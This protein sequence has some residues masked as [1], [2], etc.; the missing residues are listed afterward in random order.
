M[1][2]PE[3]ELAPKYFIE[4]DTDARSSERKNCCVDLLEPQRWTA[5]TATT[6]DLGIDSVTR[7]VSGPLV[8]LHLFEKNISLWS[9]S[10]I[11]ESHIAGASHMVGRRPV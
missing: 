3:N 8:S 11:V 6:S 4:G 2:T 1:R 5:T 7:N 10:S 9:S